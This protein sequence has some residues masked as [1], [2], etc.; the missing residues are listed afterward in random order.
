MNNY[1]V[2]VGVGDYFE[3][4]M[5]DTLHMIRVQRRKPNK[6][7]GIPDLITRLSE[8]EQYYVEVKAG[9]YIHGVVLKEEQKERF[10]KLG[11]IPRFYT[12]CYHAIQKH[13]GNT[14]PTV[15]SLR[16]ALSKTKKSMFIFPYSI[17]ESFQREYKGK[18]PRK[19]VDKNGKVTIYTQINQSRALGIFTGKGNFWEYSSLDFDN[20]TTSNPYSIVH[21]MTKKD[22][23]G[24][25][26]LKQNMEQRIRPRFLNNTW[27]ENCGQRIA[28]I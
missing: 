12:L 21:L 2:P 26:I 28:V 13:M 10:D 18:K 19:S 6:S 1:N 7:E 17:V 11:T 23:N 24:E 27:V 3:D 14:Y 8:K 20:Y 15:R 9:A 16:H 5:M 22:Q 25:G 4:R